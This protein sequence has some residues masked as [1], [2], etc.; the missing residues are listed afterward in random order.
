MNWEIG[1][2]AICITP[3][4]KLENRLVKIISRPLVDPSKADVVYCV[5][6]GFPDRNNYGWGAEKRHLQP[7]PDGIEPNEWEAGPFIPSELVH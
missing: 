4:S 7:L 3:G 1:D 5:H 2:A 6:P